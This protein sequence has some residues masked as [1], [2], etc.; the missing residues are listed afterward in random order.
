[1]YAFYLF[2]GTDLIATE[3]AL[4]NAVDLLVEIEHD[5]RPIRDLEATFEADARF[6]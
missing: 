5:M 4:L 3:I 6:F 2:G 1:M